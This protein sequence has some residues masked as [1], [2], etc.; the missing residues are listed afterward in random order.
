MYSVCVVMKHHSLT[1]RSAF[2]LLT[3]YALSRKTLRYKL[4][5]Y[6]VDIREFIGTERINRWR[7]D[8][9]TK[10]IVSAKR[11]NRTEKVLIIKLYVPD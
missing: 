2:N 4:I 5:K 11:K 3:F 8:D 1:L 10:L 7:E 9:E 6:I